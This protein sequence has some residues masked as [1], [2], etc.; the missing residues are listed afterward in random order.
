MPSGMPRRKPVRGDPMLLPVVLA[1]QFQP[2]TFEIASHE[3]KRA[4]HEAGIPALVADSQMRKRDKRLASC[5]AAT[6]LIRF[7]T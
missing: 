2:G 3:N 6:N 7:T 4:L 1:E 5:T